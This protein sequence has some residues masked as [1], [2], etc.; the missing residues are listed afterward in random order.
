MQRQLENSSYHEHPNWK[1][2]RHITDV[3]MQGVQEGD[4]TTAM[5]QTK[6]LSALHGSSVMT[7]YTSL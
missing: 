3:S 6:G 5:E 2:H 7:S 1:W 4:P